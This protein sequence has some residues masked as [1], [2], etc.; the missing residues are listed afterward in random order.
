MSANMGRFA[1]AC[2]GHL[3]IEDRL[4]YEIC[5]ICFWE[6]DGAGGENPDEFSGPNGMSVTDGRRNYQEFGA[7]ERRLI[8]H[9]RKP[10]PD[11][12]PD[13]APR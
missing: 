11:E 4:N 3:T 7:C 5:P 2:C 12:L 9:V 6:E 8:N 1:C 10:T 13:K